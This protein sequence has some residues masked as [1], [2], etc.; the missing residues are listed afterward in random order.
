[1][2]MGEFT[3]D[4][5]VQNKDEAPCTELKYKKQIANQMMNRCDGLRTL[6][7]LFNRKIQEVAAV[8]HKSLH[9][10]NILLE[11]E[12]RMVCNIMI[13]FL[14]YNND[15]DS[16]IRDFTSLDYLMEETCFKAIQ[17]S[18]D[19]AFIPAR[20]IILIFHIYIRY[21]FGEKKES[22]EHKAFYSNLKYLP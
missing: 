19:T 2:S 9:D 7:L 17:L 4:D 15:D 3:W 6:C 12:L 8:Q 13:N 1:M 22:P 18:L 10:S 16:M 20:K 5:S 21:L 14:I 11:L